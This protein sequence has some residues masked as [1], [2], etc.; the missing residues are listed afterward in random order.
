MT[1]REHA[2]NVKLSGFACQGDCASDALMCLTHERIR[3]ELEAVIVEI[4]GGGNTQ[5]G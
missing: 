1:P 5:L 2:L 3:R 4:L